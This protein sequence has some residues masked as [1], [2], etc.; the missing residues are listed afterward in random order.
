LALS[1]ASAFL[2]SEKTAKSVST[3]TSARS[4]SLTA[5]QA[6]NASTLLA[7][8]SANAKTIGSASTV[9][10][11]T[12]QRQTE[13]FKNA[14]RIQ[15]LLRSMETSSAS[16]T[17]G[18]LFPEAIVLMSTSARIILTNARQTALVK[19]E[20]AVIRALAMLDSS[21]TAM[22]VKMSTNALP[23]LHPVLLTLIAKTLKVPLI[24]HAKLDTMEKT[25]S[26]SMSVQQEPTIAQIRLS[27]TT[28]TADSTVP[29]QSG[30][31]ATASL[32]LTLTNVFLEST[33]V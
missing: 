21:E 2:V 33:L 29:V 27:A 6:K 18:I 15:T 14:R 30:S 8:R 5:N 25:A 26:T 1:R 23:T 10:A 3:L 9:L 32:A 24:A 28:P 17:K 11:S 13:L 16:A 12:Q 31:D 20:L 22:L 7:A 4:A 19:I